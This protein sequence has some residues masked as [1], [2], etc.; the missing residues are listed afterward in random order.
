M[1]AQSELIRTRVELFKKFAKIASIRIDKNTTNISRTNNNVLI[2]TKVH[3]A[4]SRNHKTI[5][6]K[7]SV[8]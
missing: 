2:P 7:Y 6:K 4:Q 1:R 8:A 3:L 5:F